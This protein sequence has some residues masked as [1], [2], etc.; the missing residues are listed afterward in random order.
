[1][2]S[3]ISFMRNLFEKRAE[4]LLDSRSPRPDV[5]AILP[6]GSWRPSFFLLFPRIIS[7]IKGKVGKSVF[8]NHHSCASCS[9]NEAK[10]KRFGI[11]ATTAIAWGQ[12]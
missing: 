9:H 3:S 5:F 2:Q 6:T 10:L 7:V 1:M 11:T 12:A 4:N 8:H